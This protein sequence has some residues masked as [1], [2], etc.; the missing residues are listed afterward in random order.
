MVKMK[1]K[2]LKTGILIIGL[3][4]AAAI[5]API[6]SPHDPAAIS[7]DELLMTPSLKHPLGTD[8]LGRDILSRMI[9]GARVSLSVALIAVG[10]ST[11]TGVFLGSIAGYYGGFIDSFIMRLADIFLCFPTFFLI[12]AVV[13][14]TEPSLFNI[15]AI[16]GFTSWMG[17]ARL[18]RSQILSLKEREFILAEKALGATDFRIVTYHLIP[19]AISPILVNAIFAIGSAILIESG[20]SFLG[21]GVQP[22][23]PSWGNILIES[24]S[25]LAVAWWITIFPGLAIFLTI[26][27]FHLIGEGLKKQLLNQ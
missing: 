22:P 9:F 16:I 11:V 5:L 13:A 23:T 25:T 24:K 6:I 4:T 3:F 17:S 20:L 18:I 19:N 10:I 21:L 8:S 12:L 7:Q 2:G 14:F 26:A 15:M 1:N 27:G